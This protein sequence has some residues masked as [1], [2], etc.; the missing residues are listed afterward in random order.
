MIVLR[1]ADRYETE[2]PGIVTRHC[3][4]AG[5]HYDPSNLSFGPVIGVDDHLVAPGA[6][7]DEHEHRGVEIISWIASGSLHHRSGQ[8]DQV[9][10]AGESLIQDATDGLRHEERNGSSEVPLRLIQ[11][12]L[13]AGSGATFTVLRSAA[14]A[15][16]PWLHL[17]VVDGSWSLGDVDLGPGDSVRAEGNVSVTGSGELLVVHCP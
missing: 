9:I 10:N 11:T 13:L 7:F 6:G 4:S 17:F 2:Q 5:S 8:V 3:F 12:T 1:A 14:E 16:A 15:E